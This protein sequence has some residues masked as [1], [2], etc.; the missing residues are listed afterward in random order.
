MRLRPEGSSAT[1]EYLIG[2]LR[3]IREGKATR[4]EMFPRREDALE[5]VS[6]TE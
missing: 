1:V 4:V 3:T 5:A 2:H 6:V